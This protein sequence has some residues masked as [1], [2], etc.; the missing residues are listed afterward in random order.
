MLLINITQ[1]CWG[2][3]LLKVV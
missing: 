2:K 3:W 1:L